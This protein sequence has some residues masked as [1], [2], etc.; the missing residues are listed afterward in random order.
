[1]KT[2]LLATIVASTLLF[3][4]CA[5]SGLTD[6]QKTSLGKWYQ[7]A[8]LISSTAKGESSTTLTPTSAT[9]KYATQIASLKRIID[10]TQSVADS[11]ESLTPM[12]TTAYQAHQLWEKAQTA[13]GFEMPTAIYEATTALTA[14]DADAAALDV[15]AVRSGEKEIVE[16]DLYKTWKTALESASTE[17]EFLNN[18]GASMASNTSILEALKSNLA[19]AVEE[20]QAFKDTTSTADFK[21]MLTELSADSFGLTREAEDSRTTLAEITEMTKSIPEDLIRLKDSI[22]GLISLV[23]EL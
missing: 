20:S 8:S 1:M 16:S 17:A 5:S 3:T 12:V 22:M 13:S 4:A 9:E 23:N 14:T 7:T 18:V 6:E 2:S 15:L 11:V 10:K 21:E 19:I